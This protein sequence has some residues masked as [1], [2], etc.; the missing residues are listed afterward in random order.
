MARVVVLDAEFTGPDITKGDRIVSLALVEMCDD[1]FTGREKEWFFNP[2]GRKNTP[3]AEKLHGLTAEFL[4][5]K[6]LFK[7]SA[8]EILDFIDKAQIIHHCWL[9]E[10]TALSKD[11]VMFNLEMTKAGFDPIAHDRWVN[12]KEWAKKLDSK[13]NSLNDMLKYFDIDAS[14]RQKHHGALVDAKLTGQYYQK[15]KPKFA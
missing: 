7:E 13:Q 14:A 8:P 11:E 15:I 6:P 12:I 2:Q 1:K 4:E 10:D 9:F 3:T 5:N